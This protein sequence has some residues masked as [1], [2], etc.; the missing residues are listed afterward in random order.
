VSKTRGLA[1][2]IVART[3]VLFVVASALPC[4]GQTAASQATATPRYVAPLNKLVLSSPAFA[5]GALI[6]DKYASAT[7]LN[8]LSPPLVWNGAPEGTVSF[9]LTVIDEEFARQ[10]KSDPWYHWIL[11]NI[12]A[13]ATG[14]P[15]GVPTEKQLP[16]GSIQPLNVR[17]IGYAGPGAPA[18]GQPH[19]YIFRLMALDTKLDL[20]PETTAAEIVK[21]M[22][23]HILDR[24][25][26]VGR[27]R[28]P[29]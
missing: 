25:L 1:L 21:A 19:H 22:D 20:G 2:K 24:A 18:A 26:L 14:L 9:V 15:E 17:W 23:G 7:K 4:A 12:P 8:T 3:A 27:Y 5:D 28:K 10:K 16:D 13:T 11:F 6:P 29:Q